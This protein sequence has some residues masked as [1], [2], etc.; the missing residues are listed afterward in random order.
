MAA[1]LAF[2]LAFAGRATASAWVLAGALAVLLPATMALG[3]PRA[4][5]RGRAARAAIWGTGVLL[6]TAFGLAL[7]L[8]ATEGTGSLLLL[9]LPVRAAIVVFGAGVLPMLVLPLVYAWSFDASTFEVA[10]LRRV[11][12]PTADP[13][14]APLDEAGEPAV[15][16][17]VADT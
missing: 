11:E 6:A 13:S 5:P 1:A 12:S 8:P 3:A 14:A 4:G 15:K 9:G 16:T 17:T 7:A 10:R 2:A